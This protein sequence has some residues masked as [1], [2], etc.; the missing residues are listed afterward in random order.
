MMGDPFAWT[1][2]KALDALVAAWEPAGYEQI[3]HM[4][5]TGWYA[6]HRDAS[7]LDAIE[8]TPPGSWTPRSGRTG[9]PAGLRT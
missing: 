2:D 7:D 9:K 5:R 6:Y 3:G 8:G 4:E 1:W